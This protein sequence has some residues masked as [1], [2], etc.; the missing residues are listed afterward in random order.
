MW[1][2]KKNRKA[3]RERLSTGPLLLP[4]SPDRV[5]GSGEKTDGSSSFTH[6]SSTLVQRLWSPHD[7][8]YMA[9]A[10]ARANSSCQLGRVSGWLKA[11]ESSIVMIRGEL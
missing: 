4:R 9:A 7:D 5:I 10:M 6:H 11:I 1:S 8:G 3:Q 2:V